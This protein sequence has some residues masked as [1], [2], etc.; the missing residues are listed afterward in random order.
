[1]HS[2]KAIDRIKMLRDT[3]NGQIWYSHEGEQFEKHKGKVFE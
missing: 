3:R 1:V 2:M